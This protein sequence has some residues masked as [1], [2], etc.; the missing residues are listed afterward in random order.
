MRG[1][2]LN[3]LQAVKDLARSRSPLS[4]QL[5]WRAQDPSGLKSLRNTLVYGNLFKLPH[6]PVNSPLDSHC[7]VTVS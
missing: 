2:I 4:R 3:G 6:Y 1:V 5:C 7:V